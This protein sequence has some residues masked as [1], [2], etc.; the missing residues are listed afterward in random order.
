MPSS[1][2]ALRSGRQGS[3]SSPLGEKLLSVELKPPGVVVKAAFKNAAV[4]GDGD[5]ELE[6]EHAATATIVVMARIRDVVRVMS[7]SPNDESRAARSG[8]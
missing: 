5:V 4:A 7:G 3:T 8:G 1:P 2:R 6:S